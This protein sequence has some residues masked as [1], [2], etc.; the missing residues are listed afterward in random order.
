MYQSV[1]GEIEPQILEVVDSVT[2]GR[3]HQPPATQSETKTRHEDSKQQRAKSVDEDKAEWRL[4]TTGK[5]GLDRGSY[6]SAPALQPSQ[7]ARFDSLSKRPSA[8]AIILALLSVPPTLCRIC[9]TST[10]RATW[11][12][13]SLDCLASQSSSPVIHPHSPP[14]RHGPKPIATVRQHLVRSSYFNQ[15]PAERTS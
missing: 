12:W 14:N 4:M 8:T 5:L 11:L 6:N 7:T 10:D 1:P 2:E 15:S 9:K 3:R 13:M